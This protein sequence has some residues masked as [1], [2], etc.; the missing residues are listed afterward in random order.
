MNDVIFLIPIVAIVVAVP[1]VFLFAHS[2]IK[3]VIEY[4]QRQA[5][6]L[7]D[8]TAE[9]A[10]QYASHVERLEQRMRVLERIATDKGVSLAD[11]IEDLRDEKVN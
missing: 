11:Q 4:K 8:N 7:A 1:T 2:V 5:E 6:L 3:R 9:K 10:A